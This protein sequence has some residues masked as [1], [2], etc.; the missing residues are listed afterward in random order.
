[1][2]IKKSGEQCNELEL[3]TKWG[4]NNSEVRIQKSEIRILGWCGIN[5]RIYGAIP[6]TN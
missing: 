4:V 2:K 3:F 6:A 5:I 1:L